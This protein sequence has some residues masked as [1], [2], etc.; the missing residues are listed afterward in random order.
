MHDDVSCCKVTQASFTGIFS[1]FF[2]W[3]QN[4]QLE[5]LAI[6]ITLPD[7]N[8]HN[9][10]LA[11][12]RA[13]NFKF[14]S[15]YC[16]LVSRVILIGCCSP[17]PAPSYTPPFPSPTKIRN[18]PFCITSFFAIIL[19][20]IPAAAKQCTRGLVRTFGH[21]TSHPLTRSDGRT[22][23]PHWRQQ[24]TLKCRN[25]KTTLTFPAHRTLASGVPR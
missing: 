11:Q 6:E 16:S 13:C 22:V 24:C 2:R 14:E 20:S 9:C 4:L 17:L 5:R 3:W 8:K 7:E 21:Y 25:P 1:P 18:L 12:D 23:R 19:C 15:N 10:Y